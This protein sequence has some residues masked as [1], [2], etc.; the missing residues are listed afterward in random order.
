MG[1][2]V[3]DPH[4]R[5]IIQLF[6]S[7]TGSH[8]KTVKFSRKLSEVN[9]RVYIRYSLI[10]SLNLIRYLLP[11]ECGVS[12]RARPRCLGRGRGYR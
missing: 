1:N 7:E 9:S 12:R 4:K 8:I 11:P 6:D 2:D 3:D 10:Y 5:G